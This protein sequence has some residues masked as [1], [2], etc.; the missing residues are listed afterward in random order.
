MKKVLIILFCVIFCGLVGC[1]SN[2]DNTNTNVS[3]NY[4]WIPNAKNK[5][6][7]LLY[8]KYDQR[9]VAYN[10]KNHMVTEKNTTQNYMQFEFDDLKADI[11]T[12]G[13]SIENG[14]KI[15][16]KKN[17]KTSILYEMKENEA[18]FP[19]AYQDE[20]TMYFLKTSYDSNGNEIYDDRV[21][22]KFE[23]ESR[24]LK[25]LNITKGYLTTYAVVIDNLLYFTVY[26]E[27]GNDYDLYRININEEDG[28]VLINTGLI[29]EEI[30]NNNG[31]LLVSDKDK[32][33]DYKDSTRY[34][35]KKILN[36]FYLNYLFQI[37]I[38]NEGDLQL[39]ITDI[40]ANK[41][42]HVLDKVIDIRV[43]NDKIKIYTLD[44]I[45][46]I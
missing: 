28:I 9:I 26:N 46:V 1:G 8:D 12:T 2:K 32:I 33:Y 44:K 6:E 21:I 36:Y 4:D 17:D 27:E 42:I 30:Y 19:L 39:R 20:Q 29:T 10:K 43:E 15:L 40:K 18:V 25:E 23:L 35:S 24:E 3:G 45:V 38:N 16:E 34:F 11:Y 41:I 31:K 13:H 5:D 37:D 7:I 14:Y 22:C